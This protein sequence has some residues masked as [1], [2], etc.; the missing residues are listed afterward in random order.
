M[1]SSP[2]WKRPLDA[3]GIR[4]KLIGRTEKL[5]KA[6]VRDA[7]LLDHCREHLESAAERL[8]KTKNSDLA[9]KGADY[10]RNAKLLADAKAVSNLP[11]VP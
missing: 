11:H 4:K 1:Q 3:R 8:R 7:H 5:R 6:G 10:R 2:R 9:T